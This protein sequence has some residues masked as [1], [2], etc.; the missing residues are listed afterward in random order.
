MRGTD[1]RALPEGA[2]AHLVGHVSTTDDAGDPL[3]DADGRPVCVV[4]TGDGAYEF[5]AADAAEWQRLGRGVDVARL[6]RELRPE[7]LRWLLDEGLVVVDPLDDE[8]LLERLHLVVGLTD[9]G[10]DERRGPGFRRVRTGNGHESVV[11]ATTVLVVQHN[12][13]EPLAAAVRRVAR[14]HGI[15]AEHVWSFLRT[16]FDELAG[17]GGGF[18]LRSPAPA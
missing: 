5:D 17:D 10:A 2:R 3:R 16:D 1:E 18:L 14:E 8:E 13:T 7:Q 15:G 4:Q 12:L 6:R 11:M 9:L